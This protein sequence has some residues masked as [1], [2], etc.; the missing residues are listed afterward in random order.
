VN[1]FCQILHGFDQPGTW[2]GNTVVFQNIEAAT[3]NGIETGKVFQAFL[4]ASTV[5]D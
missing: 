4:T 1:N 2:D 3:F 5:V